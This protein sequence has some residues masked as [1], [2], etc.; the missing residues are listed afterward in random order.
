MNTAAVACNAPA[1]ARAWIPLAEV[2]RITGASPG[3]VKSM[4]LAGSIRFR[5][6]PGTRT[7]YSRSDAERIAAG[8]PALATA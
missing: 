8:S 5:S 1:E 7:V 4:A 3:A 6:I 2:M